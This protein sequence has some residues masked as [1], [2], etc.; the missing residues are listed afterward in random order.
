MSI[1]F[2]VVV[3]WSV[4]FA[5][6]SMLRD[7]LTNGGCASA[8]CVTSQACGAANST[9]TAD[10]GEFA[11]DAA[12]QVVSV[13]LMRVT[14][15]R[16]F[17]YSRGTTLQNVSIVD[18]TLAGVRCDNFSTRSVARVSVSPMLS[19]LRCVFTSGADALTLTN[20]DTIVSRNG[21]TVI[22]FVVPRL[23]VEN[24]TFPSGTALSLT[25]LI[26][27]GDVVFTGNTGVVRFSLPS[28]RMARNLRL[29]GNSDLANFSAP[30]LREC[31][32]LLEL[33]AS[34]TPVLF[35]LP[36]T[37]ECQDVLLVDGGTFAFPALRQVSQRFAV[38]DVVAPVV[39]DAPALVNVGNVVTVR[40]IPYVDRGVHVMRANASVAL[41]APML[42]DCSVMLVANSAVEPSFNGGACD[43]VRVAGNSFPTLRM[44]FALARQVD[45]RDNAGLRSVAF[46]NLRRVGDSTDKKSTVALMVQNNSALASISWPILEVVGGILLVTHNPQLSDVC[47]ANMLRIENGSVCD[48]SRNCYHGDG[49]CA[50][51]LGSSCQLDTQNT[52]P[53]RLP[54]AIG[55]TAAEE[56]RGVDALLVNTFNPAAPLTDDFVCL[57]LSEPVDKL[58]GLGAGRPCS[59]R[60]AF[61]TNSAVDVSAAVGEYAACEVA[62][63][64]LNRAVKRVLF[65]SA[66]R[67]VSLVAGHNPQGCGGRLRAGSSDLLT[68]TAMI[69]GDSDVFIP[70]K[71]KLNDD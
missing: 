4:C 41:N 48:L 5:T 63:H 67:T 16:L 33:G 45:V 39:V 29:R 38:A 1:F 27:Y 70:P 55:S 59:V 21:T 35:S 71:P 23:H 57:I 22:P 30:A 51:A 49:D 13:R 3:S 26:D 40:S 6:P 7:I 50:L 34:A 32:E 69:V 54:A 64:K 42:Y 2:V 66:S 9:V 65:S 43:V 19:L 14:L 25:T 15:P 36:A 60:R 8:D 61:S 53:C 58:S 56:C 52:C 17:D 28:L 12:G 20:T 11:C 37:D 62:F 18:S 68:T 31:R 24:C 44:S 10:F 47:R 46:P